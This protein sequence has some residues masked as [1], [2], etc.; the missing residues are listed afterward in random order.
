MVTGVAIT[1]L[2]LTEELIMTYLD[3]LSHGGEE[4]ITLFMEMSKRLHED[5][6]KGAMRDWVTIAAPALPEKERNEV[7]VLLMCSY[8]FSSGQTQMSSASPGSKQP[9]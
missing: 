2:V 3:T 6:A 4:A 1:P 8:L 5:G 7:L 9:A